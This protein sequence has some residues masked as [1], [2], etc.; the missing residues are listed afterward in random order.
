[1]E[2]L[3]NLTWIFPISRENLFKHQIYIYGFER[4]IYIYICI[5]ELCRNFPLCIYGYMCMLS[6]DGHSQCFLWHEKPYFPNTLPI[7]IMVEVMASCK[8]RFKP[9]CSRNSS[10]NALLQLGIGPN[11]ILPKIYNLY[12]S[13]NSYPRKSSY[14]HLTKSSRLYP[15]L[16]QITF[17]FKWNSIFQPTN[18]GLDR[19]NHLLLDHTLNQPS[20]LWNFVN[21][22]IL[23]SYQVLTKRGIDM[24]ISLST[25]E[26]KSLK[27]FIYLKTFIEADV[28]V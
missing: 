5:Y 24:A 20:L 9:H 11:E 27:N 15:H 10:S 3:L 1:M 2:S 17:Y 13:I 12:M 6:W 28:A 16:H 18:F 19:V 14:T 4:T 8:P 22:I 25:F 23:S 7:T 26:T 21:S